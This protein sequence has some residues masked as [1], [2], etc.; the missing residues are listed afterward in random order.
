MRLVER[1]CSP[2]T[3]QDKWFQAVLLFDVYCL[4]NPDPLDADSIPS[5]CAVLV[6]L[7]EKYDDSKMKS[8]THLS[9]SQHASEVMKALLISAGKPALN[10]LISSSVLEETEVVVLSTLQWRLSLRTVPEWIRLVSAR[11]DTLMGGQLQ[12]TIAT[13]ATFCIH[14]ASLL[15]WRCP[16]TAHCAPR[17]V[18]QGLLCLTCVASGVLCVDALGI[19]D[20]T[21]IPAAL[22][23]SCPQVPRLS[24]GAQTFL[25]A[26]LLK[27][28]NSS[29]AALQ[30]DVEWALTAAHSM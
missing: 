12:Q 16:A 22:L 13:L 27:A 11:L 25:L 30:Q 5:L 18:A 19:S 3:A 21:S 9:L 23:S 15:T 10:V 7:C 29:R 8:C 4:R 6:G 14:W 24:C 17:Q 28:T 2:E 20:M 26:A 1:M